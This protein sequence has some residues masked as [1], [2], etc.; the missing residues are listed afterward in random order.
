M[1]HAGP[2]FVFNELLFPQN[3]YYINIAAN[4][5]PWTSNSWTLDHVV[6]EAYATVAPSPVLIPA[7]VW[8]RYLPPSSTDGPGLS[9]DVFIESGPYN[10]VV[11]PPVD[12]PYWLA[13][14]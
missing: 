12:Q 10:T 4:F 2:N 7:P 14:L 9:I 6:A 5:W 8:I 3:T 11:I 13:P 1:L